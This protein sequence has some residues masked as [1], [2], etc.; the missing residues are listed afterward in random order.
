LSKLPFAVG[1]GRATLRIIRQNVGLA[2]GLKL[3]FVVLASVGLAT[4]WMAIVA[5][6][7]ASLLVTAN[8]VRLLGARESL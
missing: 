4:I 3:A 6:T 5:D 7:G 8:S 1:L 2:L